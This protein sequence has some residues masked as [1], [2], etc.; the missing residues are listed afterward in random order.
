[1]TATLEPPAKPTAQLSQRAGGR[2]ETTLCSMLYIFMPVYDSLCVWQPQ[3]SPLTA[4]VCV[5]VCVCVCWLVVAGAVFV[6]CVL[7]HVPSS[8]APSWRVPPP[9]SLSL[10]LFPSL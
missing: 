9:T 10:S 6:V 1:M 7:R 2:R 8:G 5:C 4:S 3:G